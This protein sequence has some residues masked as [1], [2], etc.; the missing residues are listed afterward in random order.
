VDNYLIA[1]IDVVI[2]TA[3][4]KFAGKIILPERFVPIPAEENS[5]RRTT[6]EVFFL[7]RAASRS[8][9][10]LCVIEKEV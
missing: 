5:L 6:R 4:R 7:K 3:K 2:E 8:E 10:E 1:K 9:N